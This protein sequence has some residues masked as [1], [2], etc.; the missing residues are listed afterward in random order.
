MEEG[1]L[2]ALVSVWIVLLALLANLG[3]VPLV[4]LRMEELRERVVVQTANFRGLSDA[5]WA[6]MKEL[7]GRSGGRGKREAY[8]NCAKGQGGRPGF[9]GKDGR[10]GEDGIPGPPGVDVLSDPDLYYKEPDC[11]VCPPGRRGRNGIPGRRGKKGRPGRAGLVGGGGQD[12]RQLR[13]GPPGYPGNPGVPGIPGPP[14]PGGLDLPAGMGKKGPKG[15]RGVEGRAGDQG[16]PGADSETAGPPGPAGPPG[17]PGQPGFTVEEV[18]EPGLIGEQGPPGDG[19]K[20]CP[21]LPSEPQPDPYQQDRTSTS[22]PSY[23]GQPP[24]T[25]P[26]PPPP[27]PPPPPQL[28][29]TPSALTPPKPLYS[30]APATARPARVRE[31]FGRA[32]SQVP[33]TFAPSFH[34]R[35]RFNTQQPPSPKPVLEPLRPPPGW[36]LIQAE[37]A[38]QLT[39][40]NRLRFH[41]GKLLPPF[42]PWDSTNTE[43]LTSSHSSSASDSREP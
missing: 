38:A 3:F 37:A 30:S 21:C 13:V 9:D 22:P 19:T 40:P 33:P 20:Y 27:P 16:N 4:F 31:S 18:G 8:P 26:K 32:P 2:V 25:P 34:L 28:T 17:A 35:P 36:R 12:F 43:A 6:E 11:L 7:R 41:F 24:L 23:Q 1:R 39:R 42:Q 10:N 15:I 5:C 14:G 29:T